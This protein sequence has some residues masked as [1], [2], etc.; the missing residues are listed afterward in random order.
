MGMYVTAYCVHRLICHMIRLEWVVGI[1]V[2]DLT[3]LSDDLSD[4]DSAGWSA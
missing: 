1:V 3:K 4:S 2:V